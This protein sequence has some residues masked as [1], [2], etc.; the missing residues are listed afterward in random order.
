MACFLGCSKVGVQG[1]GM[2]GLGYEVLVLEWI[3]VRGFGAGMDWGS[4]FWD[5]RI[6]VC[7]FAVFSRFLGKVKKSENNQVKIPI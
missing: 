5:F 3:G 4:R 2:K 6:G 7:S 1:F